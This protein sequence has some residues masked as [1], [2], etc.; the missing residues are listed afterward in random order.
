M[1][2]EC[3]CQEGGNQEFFERHK[4]KH[5]HAHDSRHPH[6]HSHEEDAHFH[7]PHDNAGR[8]INIGKKVL[9][10]NDEIAAKN[11]AWLEKRGVLAVN[12]IS[13]P[14]SGK[15]TLL[16]K[17]LDSLKGHISCA[18]ILGD[19]QANNDKE[20]LE[21]K[22]AKIC[23][24]E[25]SSA[26]HLN[27]EQIAEALP[28]VVDKNTRILFIE[29]VGNLVCPAAFDLG[30]NFKIALL[31]TTEGED[32]PIKYPVLFSEAQAVILTKT[33]LIP[34]LDWDIKEC[35]QYIRQIHP[36]AVI[37]K[38]SAKTGEGMND[39]IDYLKKLINTFGDF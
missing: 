6:A 9:A 37:L 30:E 33:D 19:Q 18:V 23:Q 27:A 31:S 32:K 4:H 39:W 11:R 15:T 17:T 2:L 8:I 38:I 3:G 35:R 13:S 10:H 1:C 36:G 16:E 5:P 14:G 24:I 20:R 7:Q 21:N 28:G 26:C 25:T 29:N 12:L 34:Y 22:G